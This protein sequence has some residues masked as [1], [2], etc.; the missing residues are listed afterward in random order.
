M[1]RG[2]SGCLR[3]SGRAWRRADGLVVARAAKR[4][5]ARRNHSKPRLA[6]ADCGECSEPRLTSAGTNLSEDLRTIAA[7]NGTLERRPEAE[8][9]P[10]KHLGG[11]VGGACLR[12]GFLAG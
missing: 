2:E 5:G 8:R 3:C 9:I 10:R 12:L 1:E 7:W 6:T 11:C 4:A